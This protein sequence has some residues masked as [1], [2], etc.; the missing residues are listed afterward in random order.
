MQNMAGSQ[1]IA[2]TECS[3]IEEANELAD[4]LDTEEI[5]KVVKVFKWSGWN[6]LEVIKLLG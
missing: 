6:S 4:N 1:A 3:S 5:R 2:W